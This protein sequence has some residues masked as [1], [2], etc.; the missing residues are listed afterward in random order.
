MPTK[1]R[2]AGS[3]AKAKPRELTAK[4]QRTPK[5]PNRRAA[6]GGKPAKGK[7]K[8][9]AFSYLTLLSAE[10]RQATSVK[11]DDGSSRRISEEAESDYARVLFSSPLRRLQQK[12]QVFPLEDNAAV[13][14]RLTHSLEVAFLGRLIAINVFD[15]FERHKQLRSVGLSGRGTRIAFVTFVETACLVHDI[16]NPPFGHFGEYAIR[17][18]FASE[19]L[20]AFKKNLGS[21]A[22]EKGGPFFE[23]TLL[24]DL[25]TFDGNAQGFRIL[26]RLQW[27]RDKFGLNLTKSQLLSFLKYT[28]S[29]SQVPA[30]G[31]KFQKKP[32]FFE[33]ERSIVEEAWST[34]GVSPGKRFPLVYAV[35]AADDIA[36]CM[37]DIEDGIEKGIV[38]EDAFA[39]EIKRLSTKHR[40]KLG[41]TNEEDLIGRVLKSAWKHPPG[42][43]YFMFKTSLTR[44][45]VTAA[46]RAYVA[47]HG[48]VLRGN[49]ESLLD[50]SKRDR[51]ALAALKAFARTH[52]F[53]SIEA[54]R[55]ELAG[56]RTV[57]GLLR[58]L[59]PLLKMSRVPFEQILHGDVIDGTDLERRLVRLLPRKYILVYE[60]SMADARVTLANDMDKLEVYEWFVRAHLIV[61]YVSGM[62]DR[63]ALEEFQRLSGIR[64]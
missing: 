45:L 41:A 54:Q 55:P 8:S 52:L 7:A 6:A 53:T 63:F 51:A 35:E 38:T 14:S 29:P 12:A 24:P 5:K 18:W 26:T 21:L 13:R 2:K 27:N 10:R 37:S 1:A 62:T 43:R 39:K 23:N 50:Y 16:G 64:I 44:E 60:D 20:A 31:A 36:Y 33:T 46:A 42:C 25:T 47:N 4:R 11:R 9:S 40:K 28:R 30:E 15:E 22:S 57:L 58:H 32:G 56:H 61:D 59:R 48:E 19:G 3:R 17:K 34:L 49:A